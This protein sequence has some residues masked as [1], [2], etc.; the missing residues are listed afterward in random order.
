ML[1][2]DFLTAQINEFTETVARAL[3]ALE[4]YS[5]VEVEETI[6]Q[7]ATSGLLDEFE[8]TG[9]LPEDKLEY[10]NLL[11][12][13][14]LLFVQLKLQKAKRQPINEIAEKYLRIAK[15]LQS[16]QK[17]FNLNL[18]SRINEVAAGD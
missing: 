12:Q 14:E 17:D 1:K 10:E 18:Q 3:L 4:K 6:K 2:R 8:K 13:L 11:F 15:L 9:Q 16:R 7:N 5:L